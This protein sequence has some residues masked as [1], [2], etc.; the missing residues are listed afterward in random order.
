MHPRTLKFDIQISLTVETTK[1]W[2][3]DRKYWIE[4]KSPSSVIT[5][6]RTDYT[7]VA[8]AYMK[9]HISLRR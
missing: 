1:K 6:V 8:C 4:M 7:T 9:T 5:Q 2:P 3:Y